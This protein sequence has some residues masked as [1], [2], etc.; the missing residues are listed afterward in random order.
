MVFKIN[1][2]HLFFVIFPLKRGKK[3]EINIDI[4]ENSPKLVKPA[5]GRNIIYL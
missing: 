3:R 4:N 5:Y 2:L 1:D